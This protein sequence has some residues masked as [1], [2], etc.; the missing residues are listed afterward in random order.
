MTAGKRKSYI[1]VIRL[2]AIFLVYYVHTGSRAAYHFEVE[3]GQLSYWFA[4][5]MH[6]ISCMGPSL[7]FLVGGA[8]LI[9][10]KESVGTL[11]KRRVLK[12]VLIILIFNLIQLYYSAIENPVMLENPFGALL[13][14]IY[15]YVLITQYW[16]LNAY[17][18][19]L[20]LL[21]VI[22]AA[23]RNMK[24]STFIY[25]FALYAI[26][27][28]VLPIVEY[29]L[30]MERIKLDFGP[31]DNVLIAP[32]LGY[33]IEERCRDVIYSL[34]KLLYINLTGIVLTALNVRYSYTLYINELG[35]TY[36]PGAI[37]FMA[38]VVFIDIK[39]LSRLFKE[40]ERRSK[41]LSV[42]GSGVVFA[43]LLE[44]QMKDLF[45][46]V[47]DK[48]VNTITWFGATVLWLIPGIL[49]ALLIHWLLSLIPG[50]KKIL[51]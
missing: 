43:Y 2:I 10:R 30:E 34:K 44:I 26:I 23:A 24:N 5:I 1:D 21:P 6:I 18:V 32:L 22:R 47:Y 13:K 19:F 27:D 4:F 33:F 28:L 20:L 45:D 49:V 41:F 35:S 46:F 39:A 38:A 31:L 12:F 16:F 48:T 3:G 17:L 51:P 36:L 8:L 7:F 9:P 11:L 25:I 15:G 29:F 40:N 14:M 42:C 50:V 37:P